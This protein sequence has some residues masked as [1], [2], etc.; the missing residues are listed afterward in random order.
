MIQID[1][2]RVTRVIACVQWVDGHGLGSG[3][4]VVVVVVLVRFHLAFAGVFTSILAWKVTVSF[5][6]NPFAGL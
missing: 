4:E 3:L 2:Q 5:T 6:R 1:S